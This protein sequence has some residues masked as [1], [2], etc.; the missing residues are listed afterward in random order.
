MSQQIP[1]EFYS[2]GDDRPFRECKVCECDLSKGKVPYSIEKAYKRTE[3]GEDVTLF[4][5]AICLPCA[6]KQAGKMSRAS[7]EYLASVMGNQSFFEKRQAMW[8]EGWQSTWKEKCIF[9]EEKVQVHDEYH[10]VGHFQG[11]QLLPQQAPFLIG[12]QVI[13]EIQEHLS[14]E[15]KDELDRFGD[16]FLGPDPTIRA[17]MEDSQF[18]MV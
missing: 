18:V 4:E 12:Q 16:Q 11:D 7:R 17:L 13:E 2:D 15:T 8:E 14:P 1:K 3:E 9:S 6:E 5:V 10:I